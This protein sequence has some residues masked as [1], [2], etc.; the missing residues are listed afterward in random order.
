MAGRSGRGKIGWSGRPA[1]VKGLDGAKPGN[2]IAL[3]HGADSPEVVAPRAAEALEELVGAAG[4]VQAPEML[5]SPLFGAALT[6]AARSV[7]RA[8]LVD[9]YVAGLP[10]DEQLTPPKPG[11]SAPVE[12]ARKMD[13]AALG[14]LSV[15]G[16]TPAAAVKLNKGL[17][18]AQVD[19]ASLLMD[20]ED[21][22]EAC[23]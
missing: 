17:T 23:G 3:K 4:A 10:V 14:A 15:C 9:E 13:S 6:V 20:G 2:K 18:G 16:L 11:T 1:F 21:D 8:G 19:L 5:H 22:D 7:A 12:L